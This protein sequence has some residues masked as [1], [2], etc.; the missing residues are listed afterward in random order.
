MKQIIAFALLA[1]SLYANSQTDS[2][3][4][5]IETMPVKKTVVTAETKPA[6]LQP[7]GD[8]LI[9][10]PKLPDLKIVSFTV[11]YINSQVVDGKTKHNI[12]INFTIKNEGTVAVAKSDQGSRLRMAAAFACEHLF[13]GLSPDR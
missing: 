6:T 1:T 11:T 3:K 8:K 2:S 7:Q 9:R 12:E 5:R 10:D 13:G 4:K